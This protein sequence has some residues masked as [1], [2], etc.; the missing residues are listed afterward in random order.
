MHQTLY[1]GQLME[2]HY[3]VPV[4]QCPAIRAV[5]CDGSMDQLNFYSASARLS[6]ETIVT[7]TGRTSVG[8]RQ[9]SGERLRRANAIQQR[10]PSWT[11]CGHRRRGFG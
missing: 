7:G 3:T 9:G 6:V 5:L 10:Q 8:L 2:S 11:F 1:G 4:L